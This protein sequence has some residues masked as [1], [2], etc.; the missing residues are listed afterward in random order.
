MQVQSNAVLM[1]PVLFMITFSVPRFLSDCISVI[2]H[3]FIK[4][5]QQDGASL[6]WSSQ[7]IEQRSLP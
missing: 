4:M 5:K 7:T 6:R 2:I 1:L 3:N